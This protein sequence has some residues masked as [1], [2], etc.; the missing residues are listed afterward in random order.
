MQTFSDFM[1]SRN[2]TR[3]VRGDFIADTQTLINAK[4]FPPINCW[5]ELYN[6]MRAR[7]ATDE[8]M[9]EARKLW[10]AYQKS[11]DALETVQ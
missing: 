9:T 8:A 5:A 10:R 11:L 3:S 1:A 7:N 6:F 2:I 4:K